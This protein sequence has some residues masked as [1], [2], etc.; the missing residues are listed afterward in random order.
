[1]ASLRGSFSWAKKQNVPIVAMTIG[2]HELESTTKRLE[3]GVDMA[4]INANA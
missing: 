1:M 3:K 2:I 4:A